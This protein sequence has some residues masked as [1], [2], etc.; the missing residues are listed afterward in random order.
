MKRK[1]EEKPEIEA[2]VPSGISVVVWGLLMFV[3]CRVI[4]IFLEAQSMAGVVGQGVLVEWGSSRLGVHWSAPGSAM[5]TP[6]IVKRAAV[7]LAIG[8]GAASILFAILAM[9]GGVT[10]QSV[11]SKEISVLVIGFATA[12]IMAWRD[13]LLFHG[14]LLRALDGRSTMKG[15][16]PTVAAL[17]K[18]I[19]CGVTSAGAAVGRPD[20]SP[21]TVVAAGLFGI[22]CGALWLRDRGAWQPWAANTGFRYAIGTLFS[23]GI[24]HHRLAANGWAGG[25]AGML[26]G[27]AA[28]VALAPVAI[29]ALFLTARISPSKAE[30]R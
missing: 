25:D 18:T 11:A 19:A 9:T 14:I 30:S 28:T 6:L 2:P 29:L 23:G 24:V 26:G 5:T 16:D 3:A 27:T 15:K 12:A 10:T 1:T 22:V 4:E 13:E 17:V 7:G 20:A 21:K 8:I